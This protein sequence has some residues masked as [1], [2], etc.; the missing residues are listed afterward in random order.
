VSSVDGLLAGGDI[1]GARSALIEEVRANPGDPRVRMFLFQL[2]VLTGEWDRAKSQL[3]TLAKLDPAAKMLAVAYSQ[4]IVAEAQRAAVMA[5]DEAALMLSPVAWGDALAEG[6]RLRQTGDPGADQALGRAFEQAETSAGTLDD[7]TA[8]DWIADADPRFGPTIE[9]IIAGR[10]GLMPFAALE[11]LTIHPPQD[12]R[13]TVWVPAEFS[14]RQGARVAGFIP[15]R[16]PGSE[17]SEDPAIVLGQ[18]TAWTEANGGEAGL[19]Q[20]LL[21]LSD[22]SERPLLS[23]HRVEFADA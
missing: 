12:L 15:V 19:G 13:D 16:Y 7:G 5:G 11:A 1:R 3:E 20:R 21:V 8:F 18:A 17:T 22:G 14:L 6:L 23:I 2:C 4:C 9:A 10:Y